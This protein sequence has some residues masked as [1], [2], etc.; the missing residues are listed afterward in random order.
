MNQNKQEQKLQQQIIE[1]V[2][3]LTDGY[4]DL[5]KYSFNDES[6]ARFEF[7]IQD[8]ISQR[9]QVVRKEC[10]QKIHKIAVLGTMDHTAREIKLIDHIIEALNTNSEKE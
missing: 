8:L 2:L 7:F 3:N 6:F 5:S 4:C 9:E 10:I 1:L